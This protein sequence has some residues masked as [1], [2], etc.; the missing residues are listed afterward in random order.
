MKIEL[1]RIDP[2]PD[3]I[4]PRQ[5][6]DGDLVKRYAEQIEEGSEFPPIRLWD[7][8]EKPG[9]KFRVSDGYHRL[10]AHRSVGR[11]AIVAT[12]HVG[13]MLECIHDAISMNAQHGKSL[14]EH[15]RYSSTL[16]YLSRVAEA[17]KP[18]PSIRFLCDMAGVSRAVAKR[19]LR[20]FKASP[21]AEPEYEERSPAAKL[22]REVLTQGGVSEDELDDG[23]GG[24]EKPASSA[25]SGTL[26]AAEKIVHDGQVASANL[27]NALKAAM[28]AYQACEKC[29]GGKYFVEHRGTFEKHLGVIRRVESACRPARV[30][31]CEGQGCQECKG[32][33]WI[34][35]HQAGSS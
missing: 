22:S 31:V 2:K 13:S 24:A 33:G 11:K 6:I 9:G 7:I 20:E 23:D 16:A 25:Y 18:M 19:A 26:A 21:A 35:G 28:Q 3:D 10:A 12:V 14:T 8:E 17:E 27:R 30:C 29:E 34:N 4:Q 5:M 1:D 32:Y 15:E